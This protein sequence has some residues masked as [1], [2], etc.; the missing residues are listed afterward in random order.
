MEDNWNF[1]ENLKWCIDNDFQVYRQPRDN[2]G[3]CKSAMRNGGIATDGKPS[4]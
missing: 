1:N 4:K 2:T 3:R